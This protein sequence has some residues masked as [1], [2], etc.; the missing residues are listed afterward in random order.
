MDSVGMGLLVA[1]TSALHR[2]SG[3][4]VGVAGVDVSIAY[5]IREFMAPKAFAEVAEAWLIDNEGRVVMRSSLLDQETSEYK[6]ENFEDTELLEIVRARETGHV[7]IRRS[8][9]N[10]LAAF[11]TMDMMG[12]TYLVMGPSDAILR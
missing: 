12:W 1:C 9:A 5:V 11:A 8:G 3:E 6:L 4:F 10:V 7:E 2:P